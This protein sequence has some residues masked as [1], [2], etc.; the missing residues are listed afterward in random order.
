MRPVR[1]NEEAENEIRASI[2]WYENEREGL[3]RELWD[4]LQSTVALI[5]EHPAIGSVVHRAKVHGVARRVPLRHFPYF[6]VYRERAA[7][8]ELVALARI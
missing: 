1:P 6:V 2:A 4:E 3:G 7:S 5:S 8:I